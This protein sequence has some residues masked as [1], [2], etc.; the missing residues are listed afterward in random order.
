MT[1]CA[2][3]AVPLLELAMLLSVEEEAFV[4]PGLRAS[5]MAERSG[6]TESTPVSILRCFA[7]CCADRRRSRRLGLRERERLSSSV[8]SRVFPRDEVRSVTAG[9]GGKGSDGA[10]PLVVSGLTCTAGT[11]ASSS[12]VPSVGPVIFILEPPELPQ[13]CPE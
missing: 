1:V 12:T 3:V 5:N 8:V 7:F 6:L 11:D 13:V 2:V 9:R 4:A 10:M